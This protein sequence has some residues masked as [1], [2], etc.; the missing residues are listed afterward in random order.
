[1]KDING[2]DAFH[3]VECE[4]VVHVVHISM[5]MKGVLIPPANR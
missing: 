1:M 5:H 3:W 4:W 2:E